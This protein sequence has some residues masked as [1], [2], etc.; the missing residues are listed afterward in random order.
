MLTK[1]SYNIISVK[2]SY[3]FYSIKII[4]SIHQKLQAIEKKMCFIKFVYLL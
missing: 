3:H 4:W 1:V 2:N